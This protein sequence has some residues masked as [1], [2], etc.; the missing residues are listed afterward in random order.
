MY[1]RD[2]RSNIMYIV[3]RTDSKST[4]RFPEMWE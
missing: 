4:E 2:K 1:V 3:F